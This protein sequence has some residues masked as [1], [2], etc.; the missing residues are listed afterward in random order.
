MNKRI[1]KLFGLVLLLSFISCGSKIKIIDKNKDLYILF[2][3]KKDKMYYHKYEKYDTYVFNIYEKFKGT[4]EEYQGKS[5]YS[6][7]YFTT[8]PGHVMNNSE[9]CVNRKKI[10]LGKLKHY[11]VKNFQW[12]ENKINS[13]GVF[14]A[15]YQFYNRMYIV[16]I[17]SINKKAII[18]E[19]SN[20]EIISCY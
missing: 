15:L 18:T 12:L 8:D 4:K 3:P 17:D 1:K 10:H 7:Y 2:E 16:E 20:I 19:V 5:F 14:E 11:D 6:E 9:A 13:M